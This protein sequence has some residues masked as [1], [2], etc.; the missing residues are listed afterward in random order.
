MSS[1]P[2]R[3]LVRA[4]GLG[5]VNHRHIS[6][7]KGDMLLKAEIVRTKGRD[8]LNNPVFNKGLAFPYTERDRLGLR[9]LLPPTVR[10]MEEQEEILLAELTNAWSDRQDDLVDLASASG[11]QKEDIRRK[12]VLMHLQER[13]ETLYYK[14]IMD[15]FNEMSR[16]IYTPTVGWACARYSGMYK[17]PRGMFFSLRDRGEMASM[18][19]N[20]DTTKVDA[21]VVTDGSRVLGLGDL[22]IGGLGISIGKLDLYVAAGGFHPRRILPVV[23]DVGTNNER[24]LN[25]PYYMG[26]KTPRVDGWEYY[27]LIDEF[28]A[29]ANLRWPNVLI[30]FE[31]FQTKHA[32][33]LLKR[34]RDDFLMFNDD[35]QGTA[36]T[37]LAG[38]YGALRVQGKQLTD[39]KHQKIVMAGA[40]SAATGVA[41]QI[42]KAMVM[43]G[44]TKEEASENFFIH[45]HDGLI[46]KDRKNL[47]ELQEYF[48][49]LDTFARKEVSMEG[50]SLV[51]TIKTVKPNILIGLTGKK[52]VF[53][54]DVLR[55]MNHSDTTGPIILALS[56]P[57]NLS[58]CTPE[59]VVRCT[60]G[61]GIFA[62][63]S[64]FPSV[65]HQGK[66]VEFSQCNNRYIFPGLSLG[67]A[68]GQT[69]V[70]S[71][72]MVNASA[73]ALVELLT[74]DDIERRAVFPSRCDVRTLSCHLAARVI[75]QAVK[76]G[77]E[78][79]NENARKAADKGLDALKNYIWSKMWFPQY[80][81]MVYMSRD[82]PVA[83]ENVN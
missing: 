14:V 11:V 75:E 47:E 61:R 34:Y 45:D 16:V 5:G 1:A 81:P 78:L 27:S 64:P 70:V 65:L 31:D 49:S 24:L 23:I 19:F 57:T 26:L 33:K 30:Q 52:G 79:G 74:D 44:M 68:L 8:I 41:L 55:E 9:G 37:V 76:E 56:N 62:S 12:E 38:L 67:A 77:Q 21:I 2:F 59:D 6:S 18:M 43:K 35:I 40:G 28:M 48:T 60:E 17:N 10:S 50:Q 69:G 32:L 83:L 54:D 36:A 20:W 15:N 58:E 3:S 42:R 73:E 29:A 66:M 51:D 82:K 46:T 39:I 7:K 4:S 63:G 53:T 25:D 72:L 22:G 13:N 80:R 71:N